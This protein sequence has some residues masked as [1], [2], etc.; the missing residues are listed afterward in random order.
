VT[1]LNSVGIKGFLRVSSN[2]FAIDSFENYNYMTMFINVLVEISSIMKISSEKKSG[3]L[4][5]SDVA[6]QIFQEK[7]TFLIIKF[8]KDEA[9]WKEVEVLDIFLIMSD[10]L[11]LQAFYL[12]DISIHLF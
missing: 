5:F 11:G 1:F 3:C 6:D 7:E 10:S 2:Q 4:D 9:R 12:I 8:I